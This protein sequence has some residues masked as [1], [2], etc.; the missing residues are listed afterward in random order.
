MQLTHENRGFEW[1]RCTVLHYVQSVAVDF[2]MRKVEGG[3]CKLCQIDYWNL[4]LYHTDY[5]LHPVL[6]VS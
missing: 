4:Y 3:G 5:S 6:S 1:H 2:T